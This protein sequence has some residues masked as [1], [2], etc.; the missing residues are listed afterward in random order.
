MIIVA[1]TTGRINFTYARFNA[2]A[3]SFFFSDGIRKLKIPGNRQIF[4][5][6]YLTRKFIN[7]WE[8]I[9]TA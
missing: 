2:N 7:N 8:L 3:N 5:Q 6:I 4:I 9:K 1:R